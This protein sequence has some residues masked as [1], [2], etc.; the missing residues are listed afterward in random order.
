MG[1]SNKKQQ[2][3]LLSKLSLKILQ[4]LPDLDIFP[5]VA[6]KFYFSLL[7]TYLQSDDPICNNI[8]ELFKRLELFGNLI[9]EIIEKANWVELEPLLTKFIKEN[10]D[11]GI[12]L[13]WQNE[14]ILSCENF[15]DSFMKKKVFGIFEKENQQ[16]T[17]KFENLSI[18]FAVLLF[19]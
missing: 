9:H 17:I 11:S 10:H 16:L 1:N 3:S 18:L 7:S 4:E 15:K 19:F 14:I 13:T 5:I 2:L 8:K 12:K 6:S